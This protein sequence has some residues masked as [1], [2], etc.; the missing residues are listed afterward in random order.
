[1][2]VKPEVG[3]IEEEH[4]SDPRLE[5]DTLIDKINPELLCRLRDQLSILEENL[6]RRET[7]RFR[8]SLH[9]IYWTSSSGWPSLY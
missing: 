2:I 9:S 7:V 6:C 3:G 5:N 4:F 8:M 1:M